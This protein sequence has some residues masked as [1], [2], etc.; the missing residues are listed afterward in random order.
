[1]ELRKISHGVSKMNLPDY[2]RKKMTLHEYIKF[3]YIQKRTTKKMK[4]MDYHISKAKK[5]E[6]LMYKSDDY[7]VKYTNKMCIKYA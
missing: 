1:L 3:W 2:I 5:Y 6:D 4:R 7:V